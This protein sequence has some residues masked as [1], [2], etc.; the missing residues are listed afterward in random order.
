MTFWHDTMMFLNNLRLLLLNMTERVLGLSSR[1]HDV[2]VC[3]AVQS[4]TWCDEKYL[5]L[6]FMLYCLFVDYTLIGP[7]VSSFG[8]FFSLFHITDGGKKSACG[9]HKQ[10]WRKVNVTQSGVIPYRRRTQTD[11]DKTRACTLKRVKTAKAFAK[12]V[13]VVLDFSMRHIYPSFGGALCLLIK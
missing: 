9:P 5:S 2:T 12:Y 3:R 13:F 8:L 6:H 4:D 10:T 1:L 7:Y 11:Q